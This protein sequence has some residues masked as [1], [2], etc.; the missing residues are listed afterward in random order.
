MTCANAELPA[1]QLS[2][3]AAEAAVLCLIN[4]QRIARGIPALTVNLKLRA[5]ARLQA[6]MPAQ[7][8]GGRV[9]NPT[10]TLI[11]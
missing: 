6:R 2:Q 7:S 9:E 8:S 1:T 11:P 3:E 10:S 4:E 5:A